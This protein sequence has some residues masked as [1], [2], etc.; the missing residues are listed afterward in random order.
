MRTFLA[1]KLTAIQFGDAVVLCS[2]TTEYTDR[3]EFWSAQDRT[4]GVGS[5]PMTDREGRDNSNELMVLTATTIMR[6]IV[7]GDKVTT[8]TPV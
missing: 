2:P 5:I 8:F 7:D 3:L 6:V 4:F 1:G